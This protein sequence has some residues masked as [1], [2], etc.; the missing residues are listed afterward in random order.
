MTQTRSRDLLDFAVEVCWRAGLETLAHFQTG[1]TARTKADASPVTDADHAAERVARELI[2]TRFPTDGILGEEF[3]AERPGAARRWVLDPLDGTRSYVRGV[4]LY[5]VLLALEVD[6]TPEIGVMHFPALNETVYAAAGEG[7]WWNGRRALVSER[8][9]LD[10]ALILMT[11]PAHIAE[12]G[13]TAGW[14]RLQSRAAS[15]RTWGDCYG[16]ALVATGR[17]ECMFDPQLA[18]WDSAALAPII[19][20]AGGVITR[21]DGT[22]AYPLDSALATNTALAR[23]IRELLLNGA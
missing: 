7:C 16:Y 9:H 10:D 22:T 6:G 21:A 13:F 12:H 2:T 1:V 11:D 15:C 23:E 18:H 5:G 19:E 8:T 20:E 3:G 4:P 14:Q 17:A